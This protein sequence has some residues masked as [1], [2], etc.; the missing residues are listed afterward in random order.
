MH[1]AGIHHITAIAGDPRR[2]ISFYTGLLGLRLVKKTVN[3]DDP[4]TYHL[5]YGDEA[6]RPGT[7]LTFFPWAGVPKGNPGTGEMVR[8][9]FQA[10]LSALPFWR[11]RLAAIQTSHDDQRDIQGH[12]VIDLADPDGM[13]L[14]LVFTEITAHAV[15]WQTSEI[16]SAMALT[17]FFGGALLVQNSRDTESV[18]ER[19]FGFQRLQSDKESV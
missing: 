14:R 5:Y 12:P 13:A 2:N 8:I 16:E 1:Q 7:I 11:D 19:I 15:P 4:G 10:P 17:G 3:F 6:G 9:D 18:L